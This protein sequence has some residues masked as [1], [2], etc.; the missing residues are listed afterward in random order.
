MSDYVQVIHQTSKSRSWHHKLV[1][2]IASK[3]IVLEAIRNIT[4]CTLGELANCYL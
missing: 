2:Y 4:F 1:K 3:R